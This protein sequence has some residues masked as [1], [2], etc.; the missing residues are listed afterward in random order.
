MAVY[1]IVK[2][3]VTDPERYGKYAALAGPAVEKFGGEFLARGGVYETKEGGDWP[4]NVI[5][6]FA[7]ME[8]ANR[9]YHSVDY[10]EALAHAFPASEREYVLVE[11]V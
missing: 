4:R 1:A 2:I 8:T 3:R 5:I 9:F 7:D 6:K 11:G 10:Q